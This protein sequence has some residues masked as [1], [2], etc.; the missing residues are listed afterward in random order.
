[1][2]FFSDNNMASFNSTSEYSH[3]SLSSQQQFLPVNTIVNV[4]TPI[5]FSSD[6]EIPTIVGGGD[7]PAMILVPRMA[8]DEQKLTVFGITEPLLEERSSKEAE[9]LKDESL[10]PS[11][12]Q[13]GSMKRQTDFPSL[14]STPV[15]CAQNVFDKMPMD[16]V[17]VPF[18]K[19]AS[20]SNDQLQ[21]E[22]V[23]E[24][25][26]SIVQVRIEGAKDGTMEMT[27]HE[28]TGRAFV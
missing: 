7:I 17:V 13:L 2:G 16:E 19:L 10:L 18:D 5:D 26:V 21:N 4:S 6:Q 28:E 15:V 8:G 11:K 23:I 24:A 14:V 20:L 9:L 25:S 12:L 1:M 27:K 3:L 22:A